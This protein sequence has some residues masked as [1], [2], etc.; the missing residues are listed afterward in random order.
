MANIETILDTPNQQIRNY[1]AKNAG[2][3][4]KLFA[5]DAKQMATKGWTVQSQVW[6]ADGVSMT[7]RLAFGIFAGSGGGILTVTYNH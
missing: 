6:A 7:K 4:N 1:R 3:A 5:S 2:E